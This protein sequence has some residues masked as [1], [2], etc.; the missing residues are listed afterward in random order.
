MKWIWIIEERAREEEKNNYYDDAPI[1]Y[2]IPIVNNRIVGNESD[3]F[4]EDDEYS[5]DEFE[6][7]YSYDLNANFW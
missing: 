6:S 7:D 4:Q 3:T 1:S 5:C 2:E